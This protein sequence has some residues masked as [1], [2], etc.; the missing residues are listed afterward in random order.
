M[1]AFIYLFGAALLID[2]LGAALL[3]DK[4]GAAL[5]IDNYLLF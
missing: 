5:L 2:K 3:I 4:L 1:T